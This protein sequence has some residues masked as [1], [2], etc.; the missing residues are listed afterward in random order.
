MKYKK[1]D[2]VTVSPFELIMG[3]EYSKKKRRE[4]YNEKR[5]RNKDIRPP[6]SK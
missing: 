4:L 2:L 6:K 5:R 3:Y 1:E